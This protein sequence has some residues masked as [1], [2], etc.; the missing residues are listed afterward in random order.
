MKTLTDLESL[1]AILSLPVKVEIEKTETGTVKIYMPSL[2]WS[3]KMCGIACQGRSAFSWAVEGALEQWER[4]EARAK[5]E[6]ESV[7]AL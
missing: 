2:K 3:L 5:E 6:L 1:Q 4:F 7:V